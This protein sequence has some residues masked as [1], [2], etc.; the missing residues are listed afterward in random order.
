MPRQPSDH[1][2]VSAYVMVPEADRLIEFLQAVFGAGVTMRL[3]RDD[4]KVMHASIRIGD[5]TV[6]LSDATADYPPFP[7]WLH[8]YVEDVDATYAKALSL[9]AS[10][11]QEPSSKG[12]GDRRGGFT[13]FAGNTWWVAT[14]DA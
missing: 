9:G 6:M 14:P 11:V 5:S 13:D 2:T 3:P 1:S 12:D 8:V 10:S 7:V 4:G